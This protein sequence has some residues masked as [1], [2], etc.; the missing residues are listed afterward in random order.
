M[1]PCTACSRPMP[2]QCLYCA[3]CGTR[4]PLA[5]PPGTVVAGRLQIERA[6]TVRGRHL[7]TL[8]AKDSQSGAPMVLKELRADLRTTPQAKQEFQDEVRTLTQLT[9]PGIP[10]ARGVMQHEGKTFLALDFVQ[11]QTLRS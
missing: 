4:V 8:L 7:Q 6:L 2:P 10:K 3:A 9:V 1:T 11:G 5:L